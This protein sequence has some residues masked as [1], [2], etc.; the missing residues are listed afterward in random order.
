M[1]RQG[2]TVRHSAIVRFIVSAN[3]IYLYKEAWFDGQ[4]MPGVKY[5]RYID[6]AGLGLVG[7]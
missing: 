5:G 3:G 6:R 4:H 1:T 7:W 2:G